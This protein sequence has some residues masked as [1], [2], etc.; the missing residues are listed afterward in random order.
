[1]T[2]DTVIDDERS[3]AATDPTATLHHVGIT[4]IDLGAARAWYIAAFGMAE[5]FAFEVGPLGL[6]GVVLRAMSGFGIELISRV[7]GRA[8]TRFSGPGDAALVSGPSHV[9]LQVTGLPEVHQRLLVH[10]ATERLAPRLSP[11]PGWRMSFV[12][13]PEGN[14]IE[15]VEPAGSSPGVD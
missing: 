3:A 13:D 15:L 7:G 8:G 2:I 14:L 10:G 6:R 12:A 5:E 1:M 11:Q 4:V 9:A